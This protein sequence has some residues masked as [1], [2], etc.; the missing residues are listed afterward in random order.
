MNDLKN[1]SDSQKQAVLA[2]IFEPIQVPPAFMIDLVTKLFLKFKDRYRNTMITGGEIDWGRNKI[3]EW[4]DYFT[5]K[6]AT[7]DELC[8]AYFLAKDNYPTFPP[9]EAEFLNQVRKFAVMD[10]NQALAIAT[11]CASRSQYETVTDDWQHG[12]IYE[13][14]CRVGLFELANSPSYIIDDKW[15][16]AYKAVADE[17]ACGAV[18]NIPKTAQ[19]TYKATDPL[20]GDEALA[21]LQKI[22]RGL[23]V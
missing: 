4:A 12:Y 23:K 15:A 5:A 16:K 6:N 7:L 22:K 21:M 3:L 19:I 11:D 9:N 13:T 14:A 8:Q 10:S 2:M 17:M 1:L 18:F 20:Q